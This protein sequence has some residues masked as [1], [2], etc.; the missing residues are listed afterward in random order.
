M[1]R[2]SHWLQ[3]VYQQLGLA[4][5]CSQRRRRPVLRG[6]RHWTQRR[7]LQLTTT[8]TYGPKHRHHR[9]LLLQTY[10]VCTRPTLL[11]L[12]R[13]LVPMEGTLRRPLRKTTARACIS[14]ARRP[15]LTTMLKV[16]NISFSVDNA[17]HTA[18]SWVEKVG[19]MHEL[20][21]VFQQRAANFRQK[22]LYRTSECQFAP[23]SLQNA[24]NFVFLKKSSWEAKI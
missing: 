18:M 19:R 11:R 10:C 23:I 21:A 14:L 4:A 22:R 1:M 16:Y 8:Y 3:L 6:G 12:R 9:Q 7:C 5:V 24:P 15:R 17:T 20:V 13:P 2:W